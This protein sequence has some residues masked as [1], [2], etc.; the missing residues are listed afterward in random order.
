MLM[1]VVIGVAL[2]VSACSME[3]VLA[4]KERSAYEQCD[5]AIAGDLVAPTSY[6]VI[7]RAYND[8]GPITF[9]E[10]RAH[11]A[12]ALARDKANF[13][14]L[15]DLE[16]FSLAYTEK[17]RADVRKDRQFYQETTSNE[18]T[19]FVTVEYDASNKMG[20][21][22]RAFAF[23]RLNKRENGNYTQVYDHG[24]VPRAEGERAKAVLT[25]RG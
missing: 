19:G 1:R 6:K 16:R 8:R 17:Q 11:T 2:L 15:S 18:T 4:P 3:P 25:R 21:P 9:E 24:E 7:W 23:C 13:E 10:Y 20:V 14:S 5:K 12:A 22:I